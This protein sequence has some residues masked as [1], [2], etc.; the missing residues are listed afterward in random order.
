MK[1]IYLFV[2]GCLKFETHQP[3]QYLL[4]ITNYEYTTTHTVT[5]HPSILFQILMVFALKHFV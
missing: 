2:S 3:C 1:E 4:P 5:H